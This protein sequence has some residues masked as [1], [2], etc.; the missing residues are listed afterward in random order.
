MAMNIVSEETLA[1]G[2]LRYGDADGVFQ[3]MKDFADQFRRAGMTP[4]YLVSDEGNY[5][6]VAVE[7]Y[8]KDLH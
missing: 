2:F 7:T 8:G 5:Q 1:S 4:I 6:V 3:K